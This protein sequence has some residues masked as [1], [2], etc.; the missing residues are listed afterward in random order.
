MLFSAFIIVLLCLPGN[1]NAQNSRKT[2]TITGKVHEENSDATQSTGRIRIIQTSPLSYATVAITDYSLFATTDEKGRF[3]LKNV[4]AGK[5]RMTVNFVG[6]VPLDT[7]INV[8]RNLNLSFLLQE[9]NFRLEQVVVIA[10]GNSKAGEATSSTISRTAMEHL[11]ATSLTDVMSLLPGMISRNQDLNTASQLTIRNVTSNTTATNLNALGTSIIQDGAP[12]SNNANLQTMNPVVVGA[13]SSLGGDASPSGGVDVRNISVENIESVEVIRGIPSVEYGDLTSGV[14]ILKTKAGKEPLRIKAKSNINVYQISASKGVDLGNDRGAINISGDYAYNINNPTQSYLHYQRAAASL[15]YSNTFFNKLNSNTTVDFTY[16]KNSRDKNP[17][18]EITQTESE[19]L[20]IGGK[21]NTNGT[22]TIN[23]GM[24]KSINYVASASYTQKDSYYAQRYTAAN[25]PYTGSMTDGAILSNRTGT[26][27]YDNNGNKITNIPQEDMDKS[28]IYLPSIYNARYDINGKEVSL[29]GKVTVNM[30]NTGKN[31]HNKILVGMDVKSDGNL[32]AGKQFTSD[33]PPYRNLSAVNATFRPR[34]YREIP[35][36]NQLST[37][38]EDQFSLHTKNFMAKIQGGLRYDQYSVTGG[39]ITPRVNLSVSPVRGILT[40][41]GGYGIQAKAPTLL[42]L[43]PENAYF[44][45]VNINEVTSTTVPENEKLLI[46]TTKIYETQNKDLQIATN[47]RLEF[48]F[49]LR[50]K[51][52]T[53][54]VTA[55][56]DRLN[57]GYSMGNTINTFKPFTYNEYKRNTQ[58]QIELSESN[59]VLSI[60]YTPTNNVTINTQGIEFDLN[61]GRINAIRTS[62]NANGAWINSE[63]YNNGYLYFDD[64]SGAAGKNRTHIGLYEPGME[65]RYDE[66][67]I[68]AVRLTHNIPEIGFVVTLTMQT[69]W[70]EKNWYKYGNDT[71]P[72]KYISKNDGQ[73]YD[74]DPATL[75]SNHPD[76]NEFK[77]LIRQKNTKNYILESLPPLFC[78]NINLTKEIGDFMRVSFFANNM[79]RNYPTAESTRSPGIYYQRNNSFFFGLELSLFIKQL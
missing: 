50:I 64:Y 61:L 9:N 43:Y 5:V 53:L 36:M 31:F 12:L 35:F 32:G 77:G 30:L 40:F 46:T 16:G 71:I 75:D 23:Q 22:L 52:K 57:N 54:D 17:D 44:E 66:S 25:A 69:T 34:D 2:F 79:F 18:D 70:M 63:A 51:N 26:D 42:Y 6:K 47:K 14:V 48:G 3:Q 58:N 13:T 78:F 45:Y 49:D 15:K 39:I 33:Y 38:I 67:L 4:P 41:K 21:L 74:F 65:K 62:I 68:T 60:Y 72:V 19:G 56:S 27:I 37:Y 20:N 29:F 1:M 11:Q 28:A 10:V 24:L 55:F 73:V 7:L 8:D 59:P 76:H